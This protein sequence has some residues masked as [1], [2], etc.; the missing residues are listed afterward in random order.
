M[1]WAAEER[2]RM[3]MA[4]I[5]ASV[6]S[7]LSLAAITGL[8][9]FMSRQMG[10]IRGEWAAMRTAQRNALKASIVQSYETAQRDGYISACELE[11]MNR[12][13]ESYYALGGNNY[14]HA[15]MAHANSDLEVRGEIPR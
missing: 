1:A 9:G 14:I 2:R 12:R 5:A 6:I 3:D 10:E 15:I 4:A 13:A 8:A 11:T 7:G